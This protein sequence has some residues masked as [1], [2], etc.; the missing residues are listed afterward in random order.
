MKCKSCNII[1]GNEICS[2]FTLTFEGRIKSWYE[3]LPAKSI[4]SW[5]QFMEMFLAEH[6]QYDPD[7]LWNEPTSLRKDKNESMEQLFDKMV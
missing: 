4:H 2:L 6:Q 3:A 7:E 5:R 1:T